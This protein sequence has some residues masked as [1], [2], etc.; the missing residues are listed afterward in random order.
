M[1]PHQIAR[2]TR[3]HRELEESIHAE[4]RRPLPD[5]ARIRAMKAEK[6]RIKD[7]LALAARPSPGMRPE[8]IA[9]E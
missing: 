3:R 5:E 2:L 6:L 9:A 8:Q 7:Q 4:Q 1:T